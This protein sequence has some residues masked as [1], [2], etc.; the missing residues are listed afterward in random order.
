MAESNRTR[1]D[2]GEVIIACGSS[3]WNADTGENYESVFARADE[4]MYRNKDKL[5]IM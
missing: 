4:E 2:C 3:D 1:S 5:K